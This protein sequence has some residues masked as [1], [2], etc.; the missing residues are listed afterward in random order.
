M[1]SEQ[2]MNTFIENGINVIGNKEKFIAEISNVKVFE[3]DS[4]N[5]AYQ[6]IFYLPY[7]DGKKINSKIYNFYWDFH[8]T[9]CQVNEQCLKNFFHAITAMLKQARE[10]MIDTGIANYIYNRCK[11]AL[12]LSSSTTA[13]PSNVGSAHKP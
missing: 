12:P 9:L 6:T 5:K 3:Y 13:K 8:R 1:T 11:T 4:S 10:Q 2:I 7:F